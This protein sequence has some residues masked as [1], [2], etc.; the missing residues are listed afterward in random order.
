[1]PPFSQQ[2]RTDRGAVEDAPSTGASGRRPPH[3]PTSFPSFTPAPPNPFAGV[4]THRA[5]E[6]APAPGAAASALLKRYRP[7]ETRATGGFGS[8][9]ICLDARLQ[10][11]VAI[12][13]IPLAAPLSAAPATTR[14]DALA[15]A[16]T[17]SLL[18]H[19]NIVTV[20]DFTYD[21]DYAYLVMEYVDGMSL[22]EFLATVD[23]TSLTYDECTAIADAL[24]QALSFAHENGVLHLDIKPANVLID[25]SGHVKITDFGM[26][27]LTSA[28]GFGGARGGTIGY[29]A[30]EQL[31]GEVVDERSD[32]FALAALLYEALCASS[33]FRAGTPA[34][35]LDRIER[36]VIYPTKLLPDL[37]E[38]SE[39]AL[40]AALAPEPAGRPASAA[41]FGDWFLPG[42]GSAREG[43]RS[44]ARMIESMTAEAAGEDGFGQ[45]EDAGSN[46]R[47]WELDPAEGYLGS[48][49][50]RARQLVACAAAGIGT[51]AA[52]AALLQ[53]MGLDASTSIAAAA[54]IGAA[55]AVAPQLGSALVATGFVMC[56][57]SATNLIS[58]LAV[59]VAVLA[60]FIGWWYAWGRAGGS[61]IGE[62]A[63]GTTGG[64]A[65]TAFVL[66]LAGAVATGD[67]LM[68][69]G[70]VAAFGACLLAPAAAAATSM[71][72][73]IFSLWLTVALNAGG[74]LTSADAFGAL[75][76]PQ[77]IGAIALLACTSAVT[78]L[79]LARHERSML[80]HK[81][82]GFLV[83]ACTAM[84][85]M[86][87]LLLCLANPME[88]D[89]A[90]SV[91][92]AEILGAAA[93][94]SIIIGTYAYLLGYRR[95]APEGDRS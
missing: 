29:M 51:A 61:I 16:R 83:A 62:R 12:K 6:A 40:I 60:L 53:A 23:G 1:M 48:R 32:V 2:S 14:S 45:D 35:S 22:E 85:I 58:V 7:L 84:G 46:R 66:T 42:L 9:E 3:F 64:A 88:I 59:L 65:S 74:E 17:A 79:A 93:L 24:V 87:V 77:I 21:T 68:L 31:R 89:R 11:R 39:Q 63:D 94:S 36:G 34:D 78:S 4:A 49:C 13:R 50:G 54:A 43:R 55:G 44:L 33:P 38:H 92:I 90:G 30:P 57:V 67:P 73:S 26:A 8:V 5:P 86:V 19:P 28:A 52:S 20:I 15:E 10:R 47:V 41:A 91:R 76:N 56:I 69:A 72:S 37:P 82:T 27:T 71:V 81:G 95:D 75:I 25:R 18:Q 80:D 70:P